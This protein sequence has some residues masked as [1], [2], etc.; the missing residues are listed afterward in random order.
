VRSSRNPAVM[1]GN[2]FGIGVLGG[3]SS[4][5]LAIAVLG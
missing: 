5:L 4:M 3:L 2:G 1:I